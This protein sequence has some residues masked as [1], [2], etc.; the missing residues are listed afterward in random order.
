MFPSF[1]GFAST[2]NTFSNVDYF[3][4][5]FSR[6]FWDTWD[7]VFNQPVTTAM[8][9]AVILATPLVVLLLR[10]KHEDFKARFKKVGGVALIYLAAFVVIFAFHLF[11]LTPKKLVEETRNQSPPL[12]SSLPI[13]QPTPFKLDVDVTDTEGRK[14]L[15]RTKAK[16]EKAEE[17]IQN[18]KSAADA[19]MKYRDIAVLNMIGKPQ[20]D[21]DIIF[22]TAISKALEGAYVIEGTQVTYKTDSTAEQK[23][24]DTIAV[25]ARFPFSYVGL[26]T[27][28]RNRNDNSWRE[29]LVK[30]E[31][32]FKK[33]TIIPGHHPNHDLFLKKVR[34]RLTAQEI[35]QP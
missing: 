31:E 33:T 9:G 29:L 15:Q 32:I 35:T 6:A 34:E 16:L 24:R 2:A 28:L 7:L 14:E 26:G 18:L 25:D 27:I 23:F 12:A 21:G 4:S 5:L 19:D 22:T 1:S 3:K 20:P 8:I 10:K 13:P 30:A 17:T 11:V